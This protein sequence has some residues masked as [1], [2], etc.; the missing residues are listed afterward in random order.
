MRR[1]AKLGE[2]ITWGDFNVQVNEDVAGSPID[3]RPPARCRCDIG[4]GAG[5][6]GELA[7]QIH[8]LML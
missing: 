6:L 8:A 7:N 2:G 1:Y 4:D 3:E 5:R